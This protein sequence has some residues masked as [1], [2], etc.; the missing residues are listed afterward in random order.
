[1]F[2]I[3]CLMLFG[4]AEESNWYFTAGAFLETSEL[5]SDYLGKVDFDDESTFRFGLG[6]K[7]NEDWNLEFEFGTSEAYG[8]D[9]F[10]DPVFAEYSQ[11]C[12]MVSRPVAIDEKVN[13]SPRAGIG[14]TS[15]DLLFLDG[16]GFVNSDSGTDV[17]TIF[18]LNLEVEVSENLQ[19]YGG[20]RMQFTDVGGLYN[21]EATQSGLM[22][23]A[24]FSF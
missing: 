8:I 16:L 19:V 5:K 2:H 9:S 3:P 10:G 15:W 23:G 17:T 7:I 6:T 22:F 18:G 24:S 1:M 11:S 4:F 21:A 14:I 12:F 20:Y 13:L